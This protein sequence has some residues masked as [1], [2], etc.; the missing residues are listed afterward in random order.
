MLFKKTDEQERH[1]RYYH[2]IPANP[3]NA[4]AGAVSK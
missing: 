4:G 3:R 1:Y 2:F